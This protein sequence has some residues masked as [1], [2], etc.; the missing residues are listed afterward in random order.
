MNAVE[1]EVEDLGDG[2]HKERFCESGHA[3]DQAMRPTE[4]GDQKLFD[5]IILPDDHL[6]DFLQKLAAF[7]REILDKA[8]IQSF[9]FH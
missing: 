7:A 3:D 1:F 9:R 6:V 5:D 4:K 8:L 2:A